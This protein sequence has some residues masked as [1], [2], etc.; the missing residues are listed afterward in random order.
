MSN[1]TLAHSDVLHN[2]YKKEEEKKEDKVNYALENINS[3]IQFINS[4]LN[5]PP[6]LNL[7]GYQEVKSTFDTDWKNHIY[8]I[9]LRNKISPVWILDILNLS[10]E[11]TNRV[12][13]Q[14]I[15]HLVKTKTYIKLCKF[16]RDNNFKLFS[17]EYVD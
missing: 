11:E 1:H 12:K 16:I 13:I 4:L 17:V 7:T 14:F 2:S 15:S 10:S 8:D 9:L 5:V 6:S 3:K